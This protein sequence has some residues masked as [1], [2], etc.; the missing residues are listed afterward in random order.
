M[1]AAVLLAGGLGTRVAPLSGGT[2]PKA[3][4]PVGG[5]PFIDYKLADL[6]SQGVEDVFLLVAHLAAPLREHVGTGSAYGTHV[7]VID[8]GDLLLGTGGALRHALSELPDFFFVSYADTFLPVE[9]GPI[10]AEFR[11]ADRLGL[12]TVLEN[13]DRWETSNV[14][15]EGSLVTEYRKG[16]SVG[17]L[18][19]LDYGLQAFD[20]QA[21]GA[22]E[23]GAVFDLADVFRSLVAAG[24]LGAFVVGRRFYDIG[25]VARLRATERSFLEMGIAERL[26]AHL[27][28]LNSP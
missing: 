1:L 2:L 15:I 22:F 18:S 14:D 28:D 3:M 25:T 11:R 19:Y 26:R 4:L 6:A 27:P 16:A 17:T 23:D 9:L 20:A 10:E 13:H 24:Q 8:E 12:M 21:I 5:R 7:H